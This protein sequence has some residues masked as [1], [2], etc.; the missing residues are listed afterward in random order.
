M[1]FRSSDEGLRQ[2]A[3]THPR[4]RCVCVDLER[5]FPA[6]RRYSLVINIKYLSRRLFPYIQE[7][8][9]PGGVLLFETFLEGGR[10][11]PRKPFCPDHL[12]RSNELL[13]AFLSMQILFYRERQHAADRQPYPLAT[14]VAVRR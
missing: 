1:L 10:R 4:V 3:G 11:P 12:L 14:L 5:Y 8:L 6:R 9:L 2:F 13:R 7:A